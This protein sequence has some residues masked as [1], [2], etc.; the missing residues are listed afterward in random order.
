MGTELF[1]IILLGL[2]AG[3]I[4]FRLYSVLGRRTGHERTREEQLRLPDGAEPN[5]KPAAAKDNVVT[6]PERPAQA[7][8][9]S[10]GATPLARALMDIKLADR[11]FDNER[12]LSGARAAYEMIV[13]S[14]A[15]GERDVL[16]PLLSEDVFET[17]ERAIKSRE[18]RNVRVDFTFLKLKSS[19]ISGAEMKG[20]TAEVTVT[21]ESE[22]M[23]AGY[24]PSGAL[25]E[26]DAKTPH[27]V[28]DIWTFARDTGSRD[29]NWALVA[30]ASG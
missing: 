3:F 21:F 13:T 1:D 4:A 30:T 15:R 11:T 2:W 18:A 28:T 16:R 26:G 8:A 23:M 22:V 12:F 5:P 20:R 9:G 6:L 17:F 24:D 14:F 7:G 10:T 19:R 27:S 25:V 29:P